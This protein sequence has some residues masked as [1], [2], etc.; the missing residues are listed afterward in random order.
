MKKQYK[1]YLNVDD[2]SKVI[3]TSI[4]SA[5]QWLEKTGDAFYEET[6]E[7]IERLERLKD[8]VVQLVWRYGVDNVLF[9]FTRAKGKPVE[10]YFD[11][12]E[13]EFPESELWG[14]R[15]WVRESNYS[16]QVWI[17]Y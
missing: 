8:V 5:E 14:G 17:N 3:E 12:A 9:K 7:R 4:K 13:L 1:H 10:G 15:V 6:T 2:V 16:A 11:I